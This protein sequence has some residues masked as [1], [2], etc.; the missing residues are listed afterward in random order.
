MWAVLEA[1]VEEAAAG[2]IIASGSV[3]QFLRRRFSLSPV[4]EVGYPLS[5]QPAS[6]GVERPRGPVRRS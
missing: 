2:D 5:N 1:L 3:A 4:G 6:R